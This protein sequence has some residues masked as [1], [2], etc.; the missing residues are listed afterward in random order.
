M[1]LNEL[2]KRFYRA[3][4]NEID[5]EKTECHK[6]WVTFSDDIIASFDEN[7]LQRW[8]LATHEELIDMGVSPIEKKEMS[9]DEIM[10]NLKK[11]DELI[12]TITG[13]K[14]KWN[15]KIYKD[16]IYVNNKKFVLTPDQM[17]KL[18]NK[19]S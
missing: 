7:R 6:K 5:V 13:E 17:E 11:K 14:G 10:E 16:A 12:F 19:I 3:D 4:Y 15:G 9:T 8:A 2:I 18:L 1:K